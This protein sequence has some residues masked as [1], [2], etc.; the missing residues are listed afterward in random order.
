MEN[1]FLI[2][3]LELKCWKFKDKIEFTLQP[4]TTTTFCD[5]WCENYHERVK[6]TQKSSFCKL[7]TRCE[8]RVSFDEWKI[9][10]FDRIFVDSKFANV[11]SLLTHEKF[12]FELENQ[13]S[14][15]KFLI[16]NSRQTQNSW[17][18]ENKLENSPKIEKSF[19]RWNF[20][21]FLHKFC[22]FFHIF[23]IKN[24]KFNGQLRTRIFMA[25][26]STFIAISG[27]HQLQYFR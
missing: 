12:T 8:P 15:H 3:K 20:Q 10:K 1:E 4:P 25:L 21:Q 13:I 7:K 22:H 17:I 18:I 2:S 19:G 16:L 24:H 11:A 6:R 9:S 27:H 23:A 26:Q 5:F 14:L